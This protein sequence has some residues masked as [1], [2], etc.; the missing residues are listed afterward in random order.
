M[1]PKGS[2]RAP[3]K[4]LPSL[5]RLNECFEYNKDTGVLRWKTRPLDH[6]SCVG[7][8]NM[9]N[10]KR[11]GKEIK[12]TEVSGY[13]VVRLDGYL[14]KAHRI[15]FKLMTG[16]DPKVNIDHRDSDR[17]NNKWSNLREASDVQNTHNAKMK[18]SSTTGFKGVYVKGKKFGTEIRA[19]GVRHFLG[20][21][22]TAQEAY[23]VYC[24]AAV[25]LHGEFARS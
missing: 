22:N 6:F 5:D 4:P 1:I 9:W 24:E 12:F 23:T 17:T 8:C 21:F 25:R 15:I 7:V 2:K 20:T 14:Y 18:K 3:T 13:I 11:A 19:N 16:N 10:S